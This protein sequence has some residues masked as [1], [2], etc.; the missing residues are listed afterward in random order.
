M[1]SAERVLVVL[2]RVVGLTELLAIVPIFMPH[3]W[4]DAIHAALG[5]GPLPELPIIFYL[6]RSLSA[7]Y[8]IQ[9][10]LLLL[11]AQDVRRHA[12]LV[13]YFGLATL[14]FGGVSLW[15]DAAAGLPWFWVAGEGP[16]A[17]AFGCALL[18]LRRGIAAPGAAGGGKVG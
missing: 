7:M 8:A 5:L 12:A 11:V 14:A 9:G 16:F 18:V 4:M 2:L 1:T 10:G 15:I 6:T 3:C 13:T 17:L